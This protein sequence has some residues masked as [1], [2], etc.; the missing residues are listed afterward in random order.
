MCVFP[1]L[2]F[3]S[4]VSLPSSF[5]VFLHVYVSVCV[6]ACSAL[7][8]ARAKSLP[9]EFAWL[10]VVGIMNKT[11]CAAYM[12]VFVCVWHPRMSPTQLLTHLG[13]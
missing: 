9:D 8:L 2:S 13:V 12:C 7:V 4:L 6:F 1:F 10:P 11:G 3:F 5:V